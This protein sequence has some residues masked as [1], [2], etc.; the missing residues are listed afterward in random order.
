ML[1][2]LVFGLT[3]ALQLVGRNAV[4]AL[5]QSSGYVGRPSRFG[6][7][8][9]PLVVFQVAMAVMIL[10]CAG[11]F[12]RSVI[13]LNR[14][15]PGYN[16]TR[17][18]AVSL[19]G[20]NFERPDL[21]RFFEQLRER[22]ECLPGVEMTC[23]A[24]LPPLGEAG[25][26][27]GVTHINGVEIPKEERSS[28]WY[29]VVSPEYFEAMNMP[30]LA[31]RIFGPQDDRNAPRVMVINDVM[32]RKHWPNE[33]P[34][35]QTV[36]YWSQSGGWETTVIGVV[37]ASK[38]R[39]LIEGERAIAY[40]PMSQDT[41]ITPTLLIRTAGD[42]RALIPIIRKDV[43][44]QRL[45]ETCHISTVADRVGDLLFPQRTVTAILNVFGLAGLVL[46]VTGLY[47]VVAYAV[48]QRTRE[49][50]IRMAMGAEARHVVLS[51][52]RRGALLTG[53][54][55]AL[56]LSMSVGAVKILESQLPGLQN[57]NKFIL[58]G[59][60]I[61]DPVVF[62]AIPLLVLGVALA[63]SYVPARRAA[64][65]DPMVALRCE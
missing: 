58:Y 21:R 52:L 8:H 45:T 50:G 41:R 3:P 24:N 53:A 62:V 40:W 7:L 57:W 25:A 10:I 5:K 47:S 16:T 39:S 51:V 6:N 27:R 37:T 15:H 46:C 11:L 30:L 49:I 35:G 36:T 18:L 56:G 61:W 20:W 28:W 34:V 63:A 13:A 19:E 59:V 29:G 38:M 1:A 44:S 2:G 33:N 54:G 55:L 26:M 65:V 32:A 48:K 17:L 31:G 43:A 23:L 9:H 22:A 42:P 4:A 12:V 64:K 14:I 60:S